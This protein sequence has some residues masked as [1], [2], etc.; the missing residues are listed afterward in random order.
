[1][2]KTIDE[3]LEALKTEMQGSDPALLQDALSDAREHL[4]VAVAIAR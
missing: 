1:M 2:F 4:S 3:Y